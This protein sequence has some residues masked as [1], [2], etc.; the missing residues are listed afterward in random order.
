MTLWKPGDQQKSARPSLAGDE[1]I[2]ARSER[3]V[4]ARLEAPVVGTSILVE[5]SLNC[6]RD[7]VF[8]ARA[9]VRSRPRIPVCIM[10]VT[11]EDQVLSEGTTIGHGESAVW[12]AILW[13]R[14]LS[15]GRTNS[16]LKTE[17]SVSWC[18]TKPEHQKSPG[19]RGAHCGI[20]RRI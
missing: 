13:I 15:H 18:Q 12:A 2:R 19:T 9:L 3:V 14:C 6:S 8:I 20:S 11:N 10:I 1:L 17:R 7:G 5:R 16:S 4:M